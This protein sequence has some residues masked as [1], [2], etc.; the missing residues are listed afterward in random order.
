MPHIALLHLL[1]NRRM[2]KGALP[3]SAIAV[4]QQGRADR[5]WLTQVCKQKSNSMALLHNSGY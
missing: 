3:H 4:V 1:H 2:S 5:L